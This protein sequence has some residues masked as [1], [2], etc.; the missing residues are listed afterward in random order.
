VPQELKID[1]Q[2]TMFPQSLDCPVGHREGWGID[3]ECRWISS[4]RYPGVPFRRLIIWREIASK[5]IQLLRRAQ[6]GGKRSSGK[7]STL[8]GKITQIRPQRIDGKH[9]L[10]ASGGAY[11]QGYLESLVRRDRRHRVRPL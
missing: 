2:N 7:V 8:T 3:F 5:S 9:L 1:Q 11:A 4:N 6:K 10:P